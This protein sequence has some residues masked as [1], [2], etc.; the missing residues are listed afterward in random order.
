M[1][2]TPMLSALHDDHA[3][4]Q[5]RLEKYH[6]QYL[7]APW[8]VNLKLALLLIFS[9]SVAPA[10]VLLAYLLI[11]KVGAAIWENFDSVNGAGIRG[12]IWFIL[13]VVVPSLLLTAVAF[14][15]YFPSK[16]EM[17]G[18]RVSR[19]QAPQLWAAA[20]NV[21]KKLS[22]ARINEIYI[23]S[24]A[25]ASMT[26]FPLFGP[27]WLRRS[28]S[29]GLPLLALLDPEELETVIAHEMGHTSSECPRLLR[30]AN[31]VSAYFTAFASDADS[32][33]EGAGSYAI[34]TLFLAQIMGT[35]SRPISELMVPLNRAGEIV[36]DGAAGRI[37]G[38][39]AGD[40]L[41]KL[42]V[43]F[44][45]SYAAFDAEFY[46]GA[47]HREK[48][49]MLPSRWLV[50]KYPLVLDETERQEKL[51]EALEAK[52]ETW[53]EHPCLN[54]RLIALEHGKQLPPQT[55]KNY[56]ESWLGD[57]L[58]K[59]VKEF[60]YSWY[61][62]FGGQ[63]RASYKHFKELEA[64]KAELLSAETE[65]GKKAL[66]E[67]ANIERELEG[68]EAANEYY[69]R[70]LELDPACTE[71][72]YHL[73][74]SALNSGDEQAVGTIVKLVLQ[75]PILASGGYRALADHFSAS[76]NEEK[77]KKFTDLANK[78]YD[79]LL[80]AQKERSQISYS[81]TFCDHTLDAVQTN[82]V[83]A[84]CNSL[85]NGIRCYLFGK[86]P[87]E[88]PDRPI[89]ILAFDK[90]PPAM[91]QAGSINLLDRASRELGDLDLE[92][93]V[94]LDQKKHIR[95]KILELKNA[96]IGTPSGG[97]LFF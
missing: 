9:V 92:L 28:M 38:K 34:P 10:C 18:A 93:F 4:L 40:A 36:A 2:D 88:F 60:D 32:L 11:S 61:N 50:A 78:A 82:K 55:R 72:Q 95:T 47:R 96:S 79:K 89:N 21:R 35:L 17:K 43:D 74:C 39:T 65:V 14:G 48:P 19:K 54:E 33:S 69:H 85:G 86:E 51:I 71:S 70:A 44:P 84:F 76:E 63:W 49:E 15:S 80:E 67:L 97:S 8:W 37:Y 22:T 27:F 24:E 41:L 58:D 26:S 87:V 66:L 5:Q 42:E 12:I 90:V 94:V 16:P 23:I 64:R 56:A 73:A 6:A 25:N 20:D 62:Q 83:E 30:I 75:D 91:Q 45:L 68:V 53:H 77:A 29:V 57:A 46:Q 7:S 59:V 13:L 31:Y 52:T 3:L 81:D 1:S